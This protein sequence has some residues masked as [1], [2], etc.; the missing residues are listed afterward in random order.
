MNF[1]QAFY[2][3]ILPVT[4]AAGGWMVALLHVRHSRKDNKPKHSH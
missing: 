1:A 2:L 3:F 4:I